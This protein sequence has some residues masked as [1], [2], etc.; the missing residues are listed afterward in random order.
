M[1]YLVFPLMVL[2][3][4]ACSSEQEEDEI[5]IETT[6]AN[7]TT[8]T[9][10]VESPPNSI[11]IVP[12][13]E[14]KEYHENGAMKIKGQYDMNSQRTGLWISFYDNGIKWS[15]SYYVNGLQDGHSLTFYPNGQVRYLGEYKQGERIGEWKFYDEEGNQTK[16]QNFD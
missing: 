13:G 15:E 11:E 5:V 3:I 16:T 6:F 12:G 9:K 8:S 2:I 7:D 10:V 14:H 1:K 4:A